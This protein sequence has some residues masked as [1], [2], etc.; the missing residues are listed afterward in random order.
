MCEKTILLEYLIVNSELAKNL[1]DGEPVTLEEL[2]AH[3][4]DKE[5]CIRLLSNLP[6]LET[7]KLKISNCLLD[8]TLPY[9][10]L[11]GLSNEDL[12]LLQELCQYYIMPDSLQ[13][14]LG[15]TIK[16]G[17]EFEKYFDPIEYTSWDEPEEVISEPGFN[18]RDIR[19]WI[20]IGDLRGLKWAHEQNI[21]CSLKS[22]YVCA[23][24]AKHGYLDCLKW[25]HEQDYPLS[26]GFGGVCASAA[27]GGYLDCLRYGHEQASCPTE[28]K[29]IC[30]RA[31][32]GGHLNCLKYIRE[33][34]HSW[35]A[36]CEEACCA[37]AH[38]GQLDCLVWLHEAGCSWS[39]KSTTSWCA[40]VC[41]AGSGQ[42]DCLK[43]A[44]THGCPFDE[45]ECIKTIRW[46]IQQYL[47]Y[48]DGEYIEYP[49][50]T[51]YVDCLKYI[52]EGEGHVRITQPYPVQ[53]LFQLLDGT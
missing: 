23:Y 47:E 46:G 43:Y 51:K 18:I 15:D 34:H 20:Q 10:S 14:K 28:W 39:T 50:K 42:L 7:D 37:A 45:K 3:Q 26:V 30:E 21:S 9:D 5:L 16:A 44:H 22:E 8:K 49:E 27:A 35:P 1:N 29:D 13:K 52:I 36:D 31:A 24:A 48:L 53:Q 12:A 4:T 19:D 38:G 17:I 32:H 11:V 6:R 40:C 33:Q 25:L 41:A 2:L